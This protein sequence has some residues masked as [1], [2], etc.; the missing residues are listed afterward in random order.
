MADANE[1]ARREGGF[2]KRRKTQRHA[3][4]AG[5][6]A[7]QGHGARQ[8]RWSFACGRFGKFDDVDGNVGERASP[9]EQGE[10]RITSA[11]QTADRPDVDELA[12]DHLRFATP[13]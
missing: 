4:Y 2:V 12:G 1:L 5:G 9:A 7:F 10:R 13:A 6:F 8:Y 3:D 11:A